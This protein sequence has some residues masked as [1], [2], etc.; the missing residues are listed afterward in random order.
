MPLGGHPEHTIPDFRTVLELVNGR[1]P[2]VV[3]FKVEASDKPDPLCEAAM[4][5]LDHY[6]GEYCVESFNSFAVKW[7]RRHRPLLVRGQ[8]SDAFHK[9]KMKYGIGQFIVET[10]CLN[11]FCRPDF[12]AFNFRHPHHL[13]LWLTR[14]LFRVPT[15]AWTPRSESE[16]VEALAHF[17]AIIFESANPPQRNDE[18]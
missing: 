4:A 10:L 15:I 1:V 17:D 7:F 9:R 6:T 11:F 14:T 12:I 8:L 18:I 5:L 13:P 2:L 3:E 16:C